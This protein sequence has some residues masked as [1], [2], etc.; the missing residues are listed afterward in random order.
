MIGSR[1]DFL[2]TFTPRSVD[3]VDSAT[4]ET[5]TESGEPIASSPLDISDRIDTSAGGVWSYTFYPACIIP[6]V[7]WIEATFSTALGLVHKRFVRLTV[8]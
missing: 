3:Q 4:F 1:E 2:I 6:G 5:V 8:I 7:Y